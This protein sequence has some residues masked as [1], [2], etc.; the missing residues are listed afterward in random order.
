MSNQ[1]FLSVRS[2]YNV[3]VSHGGENEQS[4]LFV[5]EVTIQ[6]SCRRFVIILCWHRSGTGLAQID[7]S[8]SFLVLFVALC[9]CLLGLASFPG[10]PRFFCS[11]VSVDN[12]TRMRFRRPSVSVYYCQRKPKNRKNRVGL[13]TRLFWSLIPH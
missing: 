8:P 2:Q 6:C 10:L 4:R 7:F 12:N 1:D 5:S 3:V 11:S 13:G 9:F